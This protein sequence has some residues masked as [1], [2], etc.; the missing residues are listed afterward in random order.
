MFEKLVSVFKHE[1]VEFLCPEDLVGVIPEPVPAGK[2][3]PDWFKKLPNELSDKKD[4]RGAKL[5]TAKKCKPLLD[6]MTLGFIIPLQGDA[7]IRTNHDCSQ[8]D[9]TPNPSLKL[10]EFHDIAQVGGWGNPFVH[11]PVKWIN[12]WTI[13]TPPGYST[14]FVPPLNHPNPHFTCLSGYVDTD[15][16]MR[17]INFPSMWHEPDFDGIIPSGT[18]LVQ[19]IIVKRTHHNRDYA[20]RALNDEENET[21]YKLARAQDLRA[22]VYSDELR[23][24]R[25]K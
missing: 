14:L 10:V 5:M 7:H 6:G 3:I 13:K 17:P 4:A 12:Y 20:C 16:Y 15:N 2:Y 23:C 1:G 24:P 22:S 9:S 21:A 18:A 25:K 8:I 11:P 19:A